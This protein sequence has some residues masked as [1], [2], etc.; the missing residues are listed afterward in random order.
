MRPNLLTGTFEQISKRK[1]RS[2]VE[3]WKIDVQYGA[4]IAIPLVAGMVMAGSLM[5]GE[6]NSHENVRLPNY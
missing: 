4:G 6:G 2:V 1:E 3:K 5:V